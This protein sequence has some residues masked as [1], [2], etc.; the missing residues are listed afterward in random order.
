MSLPVFLSQGL[1]TS[2]L[3]CILNPEIDFYIRCEQEKFDM[4][5]EEIKEIAK[6]HDIKVGKL[7]KADLIKAIQVA[8]G[9]DACFASGQASECGQ[10]SCLWR[11]DCGEF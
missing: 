10:H 8:E 2:T 11:D 3:C 9:N 4:R 5:L 6:Q 1:D 7:R